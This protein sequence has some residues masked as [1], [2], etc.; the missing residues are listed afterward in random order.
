MKKHAWLCGLSSLVALSA[1]GCGDDGGGGGSF[2]SGVSPTK[3]G[4]DVTQEE[5]VQFCERYSD[6][7]IAHAP[8]K[9][10]SC[11]LVALFATVAVASVPAATD[12]Q[13]QEACTN[14]ES[15]CNAEPAE[16]AEPADCS[17]ATAPVACTSTVAEIEKC[18]TDSTNQT[19]SEMNSLPSCDSIT[20]AKIEE[21]QANQEDDTERPA[22][23]QTVED[24]CAGVLLTPRH[25]SGDRSARPIPSRAERCAQIARS[26]SSAPSEPSLMGPS[27]ADSAS[28]DSLKR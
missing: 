27:S 24:N 26:T 12:E 23:C 1:M 14:A 25:L 17:D 10:T 7:E 6:Y 22:S 28:G 2:S 9:A 4:E 16:P 3:Q 21:E 13:L 20:R 19:A 18:V 11:R 8:S 15:D 5:A